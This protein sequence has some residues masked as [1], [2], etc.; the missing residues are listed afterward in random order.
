MPRTLGEQ[1]TAFKQL[2]TGEKF[3]REGK[4][5]ERSIEWVKNFPVD[6]PVAAREELRTLVMEAFDLSQEGLDSILEGKI[7]NSEFT[8]REEP[9]RDETSFMRAIPQNGFFQTYREYTLKTEPPLPFHFFCSL[10]A[11]GAAMGRRVFIRKGNYKVFPNP[12]VVLIAPTGVC[13]KTS[14]ADIAV[15]ILR[16]TQLA[17][18]S[19]EKITPEALVEAL[20]LS[21]TQLIYAPEFTVL[22]GRQRYMEGMTQLITRMLDCPDVW[23][24]KTIGRGDKVLKGV[25][26]SILGASVPDWYIQSTPPDALYGG[27]MPRIIHIIQHSTPRAFSVPELG[28]EKMRSLLI[29]SIA[30]AHSL[31]GEVTWDPAAFKF[32]DGWYMDVKSKWKQHDLEAV[33]GYMERKPDHILRVGLVIHMMTH[34]SLQICREC[35]MTALAVL[36][37]IEPDIAPLFRRVLRTPV[38]EEHDRVMAVIQA[39]GGQITHTHLLQRVQ[40]RMNSDGLRVVIRTLKEMGLIKETSSALGHLYTLVRRRKEDE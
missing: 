15:D 33:A 34:P 38:G 23:S 11:A 8:N 1:L 17:S 10:T 25:G 9:V 22:M 37:W 21:P 7:L 4:I 28:G 6:L 39:E 2:L 35:L 18:I 13:R 5:F 14:A 29:Q 12:S 31:E 24:S 26:I 36:E 30:L 32:Y 20:T 3:A 19:S 27:F 16:E 40:Y